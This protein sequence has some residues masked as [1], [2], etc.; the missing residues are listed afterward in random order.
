MSNLIKLCEQRK[1]NQLNNIPPVRFEPQNPYINSNLTKFQLD[2]RRKTEILKYKKSSSQGSQLT[3]KERFAQLTRGNYNSNRVSCPDDFKIPVIST[4]AGIP[5]PPIYLVED[6]SVPLY[7]YVRNPNA[8]AEQVN[9]DNEQWI[10]TVNTNQSCF[11]E[12]DQN[13][14]ITDTTIATLNI[15][16]PILQKQ[17]TFN[18]STP[19]IFRL[20]GTGLPSNTHDTEITATIIPT[21]INITAIYNGNPITNYSNPSISFS[22]FNSIKSTIK[23][24]LNFET[25]N[26]FCEINAG[27]LNITDLNLTTEPGFVY[28]LNLTYSILFEA[29]SPNTNANIKDDIELKTR[30]NT[31]FTLFT[32]IDNSYVTQ[33]PLNCVID[34]NNVITASYNKITTFTGTAL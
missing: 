25:F 31:Q 29:N 30:Q 24:N 22:N 26:Y 23:N 1:I 3:R 28:N 9:E 21:S 4:A 32:N 5:G 34:T 2:M 7:N 13:A 14:A 27:F 16:P 17:T 15:R 20:N 33:P 18:Y 19:I 6:P 11:A 10:F 12:N 8:Y